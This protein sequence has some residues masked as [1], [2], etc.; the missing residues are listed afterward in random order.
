MRQREETVR[1]PERIRDI[2]LLVPLQYA[3]AGDTRDTQAELTPSLIIFSN[4]QDNSA[5]GPDPGLA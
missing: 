3:L 5:P 4:R 2:R 1:A